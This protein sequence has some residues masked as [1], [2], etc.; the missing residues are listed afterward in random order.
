MN[1]DTHIK[2]LVLVYYYIV[3]ISILVKK[4]I[5]GS[6]FGGSVVKNLPVNA[7]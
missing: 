6:F 4:F 3:N 2:K 7:E 1:I 5:F